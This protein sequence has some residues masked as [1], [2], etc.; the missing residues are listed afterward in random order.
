M[1][2]EFEHQWQTKN[3]HGCLKINGTYTNDL[4]GKNYFELVQGS[5][6]QGFDLPR[7][8]LQ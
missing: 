1:D 4:K 8:K 6:Y 5:S 7:V 2:T 3:W